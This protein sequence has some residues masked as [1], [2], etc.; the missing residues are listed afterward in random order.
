MLKRFIVACLLFSA[1]SRSDNP[2]P[3]SGKPEPPPEKSEPAK[4]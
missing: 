1:C 4:G 3:C 2:S